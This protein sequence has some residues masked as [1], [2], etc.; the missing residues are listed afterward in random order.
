[1]SKLLTTLALL[2]KWVYTPKEGN[3]NV[4]FSP[5]LSYDRV[6]LFKHIDNDICVVAF[7]GT[8]SIHDV[9]D[10]LKTQVYQHCNMETGV[11]KEFETSF[12][13]IVGSVDIS[14]YINDKA[15]CSAGLYFTGHS[16]GGVMATI[17]PMAWSVGRKYG[18]VVT[19]GGPKSCCNPMPYAVSITRVVDDLDPIP[20][21]PEPLEVSTIRHCGA[22][23]LRLPSNQYIFSY[24]WPPLSGRYD[25][26][27]HR[28]QRYI[29]NLGGM[30]LSKYDI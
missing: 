4:P 15:K 18:G 30:R 16:L 10:D 9:M 27:S 17:A 2:C 3:I 8:D 14:G 25:I 13:D 29:D 1:M 19:F 20:A 12:S 5:V 7:R 28:I 21:L 22:K 24:D 11:L 26:F 6:T 23:T